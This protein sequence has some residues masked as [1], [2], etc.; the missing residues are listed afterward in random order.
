LRPKLPKKSYISCKNNPIFL[1]YFGKDLVDSLGV[2]LLF[3]FFDAFKSSGFVGL[4]STVVDSQSLGL[5]FVSQT[6]SVFIDT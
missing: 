5:G 2:S 3:R 1:L 4:V 6:V